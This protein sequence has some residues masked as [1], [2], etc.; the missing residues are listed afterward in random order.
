M[1]SENV[2]N[3]SE[4]NFENEVLAYSLNVPVL[5][6]F[7]A[8]WSTPCKILGQLLER[9]ADEGHGSFRLA[10]LDVDSNKNISIRYGIRTIPAVKAF[11]KGQVVAEFTGL[12]PE[13]K[14]REFLHTISPSPADLL[15][16]KGLSLIR[17]KQWK[18]AEATFR[19]AIILDSESPAGLLGLSRCLLARGEGVECL[20]IL[21]R[22]PASREYPS[23]EV[24]L[25]LAEALAR[26]E[27]RDAS[28]ENPLD[29][30]MWNSIRLARRGNFPAAVDGLMDIIRRNRSYKNGIARQLTLTILL[31]MGDDDPETRAYRS[32][33]ASILF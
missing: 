20:V 9:L 5:V 13:V 28:P 24:L 10:R 32:E 15:V 18:S 23:A 30:A 7:W 17:E 2:I 4:S 1:A 3:V 29:A 8:E 26:K 33:L 14:V 11:L 19:E 12:Q 25:P 27:G 16:E 6:D 21:K 22:F 31:V